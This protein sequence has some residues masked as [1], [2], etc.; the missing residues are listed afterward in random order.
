MK[1]KVYICWNINHV[2]VI[3]F[4]IAPLF[5]YKESTPPNVFEACR[6]FEVYFW[7]FLDEFHNIG[8]GIFNL[9]L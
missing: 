2:D 1:D 5:A 4:C 3:I 8:M 7:V 6:I 9:D